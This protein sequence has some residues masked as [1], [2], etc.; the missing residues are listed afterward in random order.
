MHEGIEAPLPPLIQG[1]GASGSERGA[2]DSMEKCEKIYRTVRAQV[3]TNRCR[4]QD[5][6]RQPRFHQFGEIGQHA[7]VGR[8]GFGTR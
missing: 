1:G 5:K 8:G 4:Q 3:I 7:A 6:K 2:E